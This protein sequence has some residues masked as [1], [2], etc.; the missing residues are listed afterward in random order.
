MG[1][2]ETMKKGRMGSLS[3][4][5]LKMKLIMFVCAMLVVI[6]SVLAL[7]N[8]FSLSKAITS[9]VDDM[10]MPLATESA[11]DISSKVAM[12]KAQSETVLLRTLSSNG[13]GVDLSTNSYIR[14]QIRDTKIGAKSFV[15][16]KAGGY[17][18]SSDDIK[19]ADCDAIKKQDVYINARKTNTTT[20]ST[21]VVTEDGTSAEFSIVV[22]GMLNVTS[23]TLVLNF[24]ISALSGIVETVQ[25]GETGKAYIIDET[26][27]TI[28]DRDIQNVIDGFNAITMAETDSSYKDLAEASTLALSGESGVMLGKANGVPSRIAYAPVQ[29]SP[30]AIILVAPESEFTSPMKTSITMIIIF[31]VIMLVVAVILT[32][33][34]MNGIVS[35]IIGVTD[36]LKKLSEGDLASPVK[37]LHQKNEIGVL[38]ASL[39]ETVSS[40]RT[41]ID[42]ISKSLQDISEGNLAF[43]MDGSFKGDFVEIKNS[44]NSI[45]ADLRATFEQ[46]NLAANQVSDGASQV[47][48]GAQLL[49]VGA[50]QQ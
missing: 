17:F 4:K 24:D 10:V 38:S 3:F 13:I 50:L 6:V 40:L 20:V 35:P 36:R 21:P 45:L 28:A 18:T 15:I 32:F 23:Y 19:E 12:L 34:I 11:A 2:V 37:V 41:Y 49:S 47:A 1:T 25:F 43:E 9:T 46:I 39:E 42:R 26:G 30:W 7:M 44:F 31:S 22:P 14:Q 8:Y 27:R 16:F 29:D 48:A 5:G 33:V